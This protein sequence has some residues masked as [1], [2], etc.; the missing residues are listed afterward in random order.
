MIQGRQVRITE[1]KKVEDAIKTHT[2]GNGFT[3]TAELSVQQV[4][5]D[6]VHGLIEHKIVLKLDQAEYE[7]LRQHLGSGRLELVI[8]EQEKR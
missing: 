7:W 8:R 4:P 6:R 3:Y 1:L 2:M 5:G